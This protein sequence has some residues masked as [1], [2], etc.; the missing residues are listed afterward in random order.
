[1]PLAV[2]VPKVF[3]AVVESGIGHLREHDTAHN[4]N[5]MPSGLALVHRAG[6]PTNRTGLGSWL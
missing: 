5:P 6:Q 4:R 3:E 2:T 1:M